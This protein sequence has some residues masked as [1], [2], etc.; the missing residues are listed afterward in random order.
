MNNEFRCGIFVDDRSKPISFVMHRTHTLLL[1]C[2]FSQDK[3]LQ[4][5]GVVRSSSPSSCSRSTPTVSLSTSAAI[6]ATD[7]VTSAAAPAVPNVTNIGVPFDVM[8]STR[9]MSPAVAPSPELILG[10]AT[11]S[12][13]DPNSNSDELRTTVSKHLSP[14]DV[15][16]SKSL[17]KPTGESSC[18]MND[19]TPRAATQQCSSRPVTTP[20]DVLSLLPPEIRVSLAAQDDDEID[21]E[22][23]AVNSSVQLD[24][25]DDDD[26]VIILSSSTPESDDDFQ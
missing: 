10:S 24:R 1:H 2:C 15:F 20:E 4:T 23:E 14:S 11:H 18:Q 26:D 3:V 17:D 21:S 7:V 13:K 9:S 5:S 8:H 25:G 16:N 6:I 22:V 12:R 19:E